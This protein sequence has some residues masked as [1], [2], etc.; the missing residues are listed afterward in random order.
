MTFPARR[1]RLNPQLNDD[2]VGRPFRVGNASRR[3]ST[4]ILIGISA[5][6]GP[7]HSR[8]RHRLL[9]AAIT[10]S[11]GSLEADNFHLVGISLLRFHNL[12]LFNFRKTLKSSNTKK[13]DFRN[14]ASIARLPVAS[15]EHGT[16]KLPIA[17]D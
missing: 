3:S 10:L 8:A 2:C 13:I 17:D 16:C 14:A 1:Q 6:S 15:V 11:D 4:S 12:P 5:A 7:P 9:V